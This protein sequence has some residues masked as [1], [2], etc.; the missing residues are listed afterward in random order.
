MQKSNMFPHTHAIAGILLGIVGYK[1]G[2]IT[3]YDI[4]IISILTTII[5]IDHYIMHILIMKDYSLFGFWNQICKLKHPLY[6]SI[7]H[8]KQGMVLMTII[9]AIIL[10]FSQRIAFII[11]SAYFMHILLDNMYRIKQFNDYKYLKF[12]KIRYKTSV[13]EAFTFLIFLSISIMLWFN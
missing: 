1:L 5:D 11:A 7:I 4:L 8:R 10:Y 2:L 13:S 9:S 12:K 6:R 3:N